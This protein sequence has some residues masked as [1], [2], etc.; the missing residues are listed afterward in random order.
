MPRAGN[1]VHL[2]EVL[3]REQTIGPA[4]LPK[5]VRRSRA[6]L[7]EEC[8]RSRECRVRATQSDRQDIFPK[9]R[10][11]VREKGGIGRPW[12][13]FAFRPAYH[14]ELAGTGRHRVRNL[15]ARFDAQKDLPYPARPTAVLQ[16][17]R[18]VR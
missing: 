5:E 14:T 3:H 6:C 10:P 7:E 17:A 18:L 9:K 11:N 12:G 4:A 13:Q 16:W 1:A 8:L 2:Q 15:N